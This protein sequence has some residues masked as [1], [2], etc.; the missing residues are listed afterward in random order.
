[1]KCESKYHEFPKEKYTVKMLSAKWQSFYLSLSVFQTVLNRIFQRNGTWTVLAM[2][3]VIDHDRSLFSDNMSICGTNMFDVM[4][5]IKILRFFLRFVLDS[6]EK[7]WQ[8]SPD[9]VMVYDYI[10]IVSYRIVSIYMCSKHN[11]THYGIVMLYDNIDLGQHWFRSWLFAWW[12]QTIIS[13]N[14]DL[15][16]GFCITQ[17]RP[18]SQEI[19]DT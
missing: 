5:C 15:S 10:H 16:S 1:M 11:F 17:W 12:Y 7:C 4:K 19:S 8:K 2:H 3:Y 18:I 9:I 14:V 13:T 6:W